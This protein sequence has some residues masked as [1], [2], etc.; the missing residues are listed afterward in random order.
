MN[1]FQRWIQARK[2][3]DGGP[4]CAHLYDLDHLKT[5]TRAIVSSL[6]GRFRMY[7]AMKANSEPLILDTLVSVV[8]GFETASLGEV[9]KAR[10]AGK[11]IPV[12]FGGPGKTDEEMEEAV[13]LGVERIH[14]ESIQELRRVSWIAGR[15]GVHIP[16]LLRV[17]LKGPF[18]SA[19]LHMAGRPT[20]FGIDEEEVPE[21]IR[22]ARE[23][24]GVNLEGFHFHSLSNNLDVERHLRLLRLYMEKVAGWEKL[25]GVRSKVINVGGGIGIDFADP[26][27]SFDWER[28]L[29]GLSAL[30][31][32]LPETVETIQF[33]CGRYLTASCGGYAVEVLDLKQNHGKNY[34]VVRGGTHHF[35]LPA[36]WQHSHPFEVVPVDRWDYPFPRKEWKDTAV[37]V[38]GQLCTPKDVLAR[39]A[40]VSRLRI[41]DVLLFRYTGAYGWS[42]SHHDFLSHPHPDQVYFRERSLQ[43]EGGVQR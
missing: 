9:R 16:V 23:L 13:R 4:V 7:Y 15:L 14:V 10:T 6:P 33:E 27:A 35:R 37:T 20:Q 38:V 36:S 34:A 30:E 26:D 24:E 31:R 43:A 25:F 1:R 3:E 5:H 2:A 28:F 41:G 17:N 32:E 19:T 8:H 22:M 29:P 42:I 18:P 40:A 12:I 11:T 39:E 21:A